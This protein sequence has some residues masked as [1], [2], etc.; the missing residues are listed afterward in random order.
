MNADL[1]S[2]I[3]ARLQRAT[4]IASEMLQRSL[5]N[6]SVA[7][8]LELR[9]ANRLVINRNFQRREVWKTTPKVYLVD[10]ILRGMPIPKMYFRTLVD[11]ETQSSVREVIDGQQ[12]LQAIFQFADNDLRLSAHAREFAGLRYRDLDSEQ[13]EQF[14]SYTFAAEQLI[15]ADDNDVLEVFARINTY[16]VSLKPAELRHARWQGE[17]KWAAHEARGRAS[18]VS[19]SFDPPS[20]MQSVRTAPNWPPAPVE[21]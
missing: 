5:H 14:L 17:F 11:A 10:S 13:K 21:C 1:V 9:V 8:F 16:N 3:A 19:S 18:C 20:G 4:R 12:R 15:N 6:Y 2:R 7:D